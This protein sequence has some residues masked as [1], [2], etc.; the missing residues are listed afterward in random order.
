[1]CVFLFPVDGSSKNVSSKICCI[2]FLENNLFFS[3]GKKKPLGFFVC[4]LS[5]VWSHVHAI[6]TKTA[7]SSRAYAALS[8]VW[9]GDQ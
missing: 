3:P 8:E 7:G 5:V 2:F 6:L 1:M 9:D 4:F